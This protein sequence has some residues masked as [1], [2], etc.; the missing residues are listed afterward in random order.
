MVF[1]ATIVNLLRLGLSLYNWEVLAGLFSSTSSQPWLPV[2]LA[3]SGLVWGSLGL[4][5]TLGLWKGKS[6]T[7]YLYLAALVAYS[8]YY[9]LDRMFLAGYPQRNYNWPFALTVN[10]L[11][12]LYSLW[13]FT[14]PRIRLFF[15]VRYE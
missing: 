15:G 8:L 13:T 9:W 5:L 3:I 2:Y 12:L 6:R 10:L 4:P 11:I 14:R 1:I 7:P